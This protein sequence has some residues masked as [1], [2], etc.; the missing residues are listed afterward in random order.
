MKKFIGISVAWLAAC[1]SSGQSGGQSPNSSNA[2]VTMVETPPDNCKKVGSVQG[3]G[4]DMDGHIADQAAQNS[5]A[6]HAQKMGATH[7]VITAKTKDNVAEND[8][9]WVLTQISADAYACPKP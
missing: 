2:N 1:A 3:R 9:T 4:H 5:A 7:L 6:E 8:G